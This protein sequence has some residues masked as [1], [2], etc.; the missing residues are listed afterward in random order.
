LL[1]NASKRMLMLACEVKYLRHLRG[2]DIMD[3]QHDPRGGLVVLAEHVLQYVN[4]ELHGRVV[5]IQEPHFGQQSRGRVRDGLLS[6]SFA[7]GTIVRIPFDDL[8]ADVARRVVTCNAPLLQETGG[9]ALFN[10]LYREQ[11]ATRA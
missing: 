8:M 5:V 11:A 2:G 4:H 1:Q 10:Y 3:F 6:G 9:R 7:T